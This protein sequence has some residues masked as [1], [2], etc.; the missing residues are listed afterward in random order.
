MGLNSAFV[1][2]A[3]GPQVICRK[4]HNYSFHCRSVVYFDFPI[5][6]NGENPQHKLTRCGINSALRVNFSVAPVQF[7]HSVWMRFVNV[8]LYR[9]SAHKIWMENPQRACYIFGLFILGEMLFYKNQHF[10]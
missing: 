2:F 10:R 5:E 4:I 9:F 3:A 8:I 1:D 7:F 6:V